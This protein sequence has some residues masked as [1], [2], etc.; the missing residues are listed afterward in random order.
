MADEGA[1][2]VEYRVGKIRF[3]LIHWLCASKIFCQYPLAEYLSIIFDIS[4]ILKWLIKYPLNKFEIPLFILF[5][6]LN[7][8]LHFVVHFCVGPKTGRFAQVLS[9]LLL[10]PVIEHEDDCV[11]MQ[12]VERG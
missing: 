1:C 5:I 11:A 6:L 8:Q 7:M 12:F 2:G 9:A 3:R 4:G 10:E